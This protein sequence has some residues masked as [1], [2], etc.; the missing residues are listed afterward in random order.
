MPNEGTVLYFALTV[1]LDF[2][3]FLIFQVT[4]VLED[5]K[6]DFKMSF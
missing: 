4:V 5:K 6:F 1:N 2:T 3:N